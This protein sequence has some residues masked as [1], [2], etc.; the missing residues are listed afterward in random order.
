MNTKENIIEKTIER[1]ESYIENH[2]CT[3]RGVNWKDEDNHTIRFKQLLKL[4]EEKENFTLNDLGCGY[5]A[6]YSFMLQNGYKKFKYNGYD[7]VEKFIKN[8]QASFKTDE[9]AAFY[10]VNDHK[11]LKMAD[12]TIGCGLMSY[13]YSHKEHEWL[14][15]ILEI[16]EY[17]NLN[18]LKGFSF[19]ILT[20]YSDVD[21]RKACNYYAD[22]LFFFD[23]CKRNYS[24]NVALLH[25][26]NLYDFTIIVRK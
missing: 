12:Y 23:Y 1:F 19:N 21:K 13:K 18:S 9:N 8:A 7:V 24:K 6:L 11:D 2:G 15:Y 17:M 26:Y 20:I 25:D 10:K 5:G 14:S 3:T 22:P 16:I 4:I